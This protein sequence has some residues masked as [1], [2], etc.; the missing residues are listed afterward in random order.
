MTGVIE[1]RIATE[2]NCRRV[3]LL[4]H[5]RLGDTIDQINRNRQQHSLGEAMYRQLA[6]K[7][8]ILQV[9]AAPALSKPR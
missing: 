7:I 5:E 1:I 4:D 3:K 6:A 9:P 8:G 2:R